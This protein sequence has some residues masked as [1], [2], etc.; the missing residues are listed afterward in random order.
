MAVINTELDLDNAIGHIARGLDTAL[1]EKI[2]AA[3]M[4]HAEKVVEEAASK[5]CQNLKS[6]I[7]SYREHADGSVK[8]QMVINGVSH[9]I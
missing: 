5:L 7:R 9:E 8:V 2:K 6:H 1:K 3:L 4:P